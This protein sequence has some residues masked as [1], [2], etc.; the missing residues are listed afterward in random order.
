MNKNLAITLFTVGLLLCFGGAGGVE[1]SM[2]TL[3]LLGSTVVAGIGLLMM[4]LGTEA[5][6]DNG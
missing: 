2:T 4:W 1:T 3:A 6:K 5:L